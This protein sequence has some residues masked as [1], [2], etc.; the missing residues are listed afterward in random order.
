MV[1][2]DVLSPDS[3]DSLNVPYKISIVREGHFLDSSEE[4]Q[5]TDKESVVLSHL[6]DVDLILLVELFPSRFLMALLLVEKSEALEDTVKSINLQELKKSF[7]LFKVL[8]RKLSQNQGAFR[9]LND[10]FNVREL[11]DDLLSFH[12][13]LS[14]SLKESASSLQTHDDTVSF[15]SHKRRSQIMELPES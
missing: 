6:D 3:V 13:N 11:L 14:S 1:D 8:G 10:I 9:D 4:V 15:E 5:G 2:D 7:F 12:K